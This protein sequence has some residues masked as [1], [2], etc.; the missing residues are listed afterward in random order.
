[1]NGRNNSFSQTII[2]IFCLNKKSL[3]RYFVYGNSTLLKNNYCSSKRGLKKCIVLIWFVAIIY[4]YFDLIF[5]VFYIKN[6]NEQLV[7]A[8]FIN[9][10]R[11]HYKNI[12]KVNICLLDPPEWSLLLPE[13]PNFVRVFAWLQFPVEGFPYYRALR[14]LDSFPT[15]RVTSVY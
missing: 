12:F 11:K 2:F 4:V 9:S 6:S 1:M 3:L 8:T 15:I 7:Y 13:A 14:I 5:N 10:Y